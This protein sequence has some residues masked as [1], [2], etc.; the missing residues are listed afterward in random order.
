MKEKPKVIKKKKKAREPSTSSATS[1]SSSSDSGSES[2]EEMSPKKQTAR[3]AKIYSFTLLLH[4]H[5]RICLLDPLFR[6]ELN[7]GNICCHS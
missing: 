4:Y 7:N 6:D 2:D 3:H 5:S 1:S